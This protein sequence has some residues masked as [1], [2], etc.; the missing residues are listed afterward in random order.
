MTTVLNVNINDLSTQF[1]RELRGRFDNSAQIEIRIVAPKHGEGLLSDNDF[2]GIINLLDWKKKKRD[3]I[4]APAIE[5]LSKMPISNIYL[6]QDFL[7]EKL[8]QL[9]TRLHGDAYLKKDGGEYLSV[10][11]FLYVR[12]A[13]IAEGQEYYE[14]VLRNSDEMPCEI[15]FEHLLSIAEGAYLKKTKKEFSYFPTHNYETGSNKIAWK[16]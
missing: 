6:F 13:V 8:F 10:D 9:D 12:C 5:A 7:S 3:S 4:I 1:I 15:D 11:D 14:N 16:K 2:W